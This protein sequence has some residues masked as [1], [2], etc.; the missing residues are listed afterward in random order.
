MGGGEE[1]QKSSVRLQISSAQ[2][3]SPARSLH[4]KGIPESRLSDDARRGPPRDK[5]GAAGIFSAT[6]ALPECEQPRQ[7]MGEAA[8][9]DQ[10]GFLK[11]PGS[12]PFPEAQ[13]GSCCS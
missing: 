5:A 12:W 1:L 13:A 3:S 10:K 2:T 8:R 11:A 6:S 4:T 9:E 7:K